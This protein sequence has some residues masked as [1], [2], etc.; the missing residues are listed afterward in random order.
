MSMDTPGAGAKIGDFNPEI[1]HNQDCVLDILN[2]GNIMQDD[3]FIR[4]QTG[5]QQF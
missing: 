3:H 5:R 2:S 1:T 4:K